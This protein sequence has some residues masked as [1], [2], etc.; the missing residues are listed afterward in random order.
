MFNG[1]STKNVKEIKRVGDH[2]EFGNLHNLDEAGFYNMLKGKY[3]NNPKDKIFL[4]QL[5]K[6]MGYANGFSEVDTKMFSTT[7]LPRGTVGYMGYNAAHQSYY[8]RLDASNEEDT[9][10]F[11]INAKNGCTMHFMKTAGSHFFFCP[12]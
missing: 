7:Q 1:V 4:D 10:A 5:F 8:G 6:H 9:Q 3:D 12:N 2:P 11:R